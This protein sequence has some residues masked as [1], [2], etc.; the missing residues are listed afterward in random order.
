MRRHRIE[1]LG[2]FGGA[3][4]VGHVPGD[5]D[6]I[7]RGLGV[8]DLKL[9]QHPLQSVIAARARSSALDAKAVAL[10]DDMDVRQMHDAP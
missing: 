10:A 4:G 1:E 6:E 8:Q 2:P 7:E 3:A 9:V 5:Q